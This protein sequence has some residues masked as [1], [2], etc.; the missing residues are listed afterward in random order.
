MGSI[1]TPLPPLPPLPPQL[2]VLPQPPLLVAAGCGLAIE[3]ARFTNTGIG[4]KSKSNAR[5]RP[6]GARPVCPSGMARNSSKQA[7]IRGRAASHVRAV[8]VGPFP[9]CQPDWREELMKTAKILLVVLV[10][11]SGLT[12]CAG[13]SRSRAA[14]ESAPASGF[15][16]STPNGQGY[17]SDSG[18]EVGHAPE[19]EWAEVQPSSVPSPSPPAAGVELQGDRDSAAPAAEAHGTRPAA[20]ARPGLGTMWGENR[21]S[22][23]S[24]APFLR[25][26]PN[27]PF[28]TL[29]IH[30][31][32]AQGVRAMAAHGQRSDWGDNVFPAAAHQLSVRVL[33]ESYGPLPGIRAGGRTYV[34]GEAS[35]RYVLRIQNHTGN[36]VEVVATVDGLDVIDGRA[37]SFGKR[38]YLLGPWATLDIEGF[39]RS[40]STVAAFRFGSVRDSYA[41]R[42]GQARNVGVIGIAFFHELGSTW[43]WTEEEIR[44]RHDA[45]P[46]PG[47]YADPPP[48]W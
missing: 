38:G 2:L 22:Q 46:F 9:L 27:S 14:A 34:I 6:T 10:A 45:D 37:G 48:P 3:D 30:Y 5:A 35:Q 29:S 28:A 32:D 17:A 47:R 21:H 36:R 42:K 12:G 41:A 19:S 24:T 4:R 39:R 44:L 8:G 25:A 31:N 18:D 16:D 1:P 15:A 26:E 23:V 33:D 43:P 13:A 7:R 11:L 20:K 40:D